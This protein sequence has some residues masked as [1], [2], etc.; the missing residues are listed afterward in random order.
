VAL[1]L[2]QANYTAASVKAMVASPQD[3]EAAARPL[4]E[5]VGAKLMHLYFSF[6][7]H[8]IVALIE[9]PDDAAMMA[10]TMAIGASGSLT[11]G[12][13]TKL[14]TAG[15]AMTAMATA[16]RVTGAFRPANA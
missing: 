5:A 2:Y 13:T 1:Y 4:L 15:E 10:G 3:R 12:M 9:A 6:G 11:G 8:D 14:M 7:S 16:A